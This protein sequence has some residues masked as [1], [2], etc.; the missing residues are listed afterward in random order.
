[1]HDVNLCKSCVIVSPQLF[2]SPSS[3]LY[4]ICTAVSIAWYGGFRIPS[5]ENCCWGGGEAGQST[6]GL[7]GHPQKKALEKHFP[8]FLRGIFIK[9]ETCQFLA[10]INSRFCNALYKFLQFW[11]IFCVG[12]PHEAWMNWFC[13]C[14]YIFT[15]SM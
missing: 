4:Q 5:E 1:M 14:W 8:C 9:V 3:F 11:N 2:L 12:N 15:I 6:K 10:F 13:C 7:W